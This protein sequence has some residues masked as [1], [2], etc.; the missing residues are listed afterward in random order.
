MTLKNTKLLISVLA[1]VAIALSCLVFLGMRK[2]RI[3]NEETSLLLISADEIAAESAALQS[4]RAARVT[5]KIEIEEFESLVL[6]DEKLVGAIESIEN[7]GRRLGLS[8]DT[9]SVQNEVED[10]STHNKVNLMV[11]TEGDWEPTMQFLKAVESQPYRVM[12][13][14]VHFQKEE[15]VWLSRI[16]LSL[17]IFK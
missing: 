11:E 5:S 1:F 4:I 3:Q 10:S 7:A 15:G 9:V 8:T 13:D 16:G 2:T 12:I 14:E 6:T 17:Y